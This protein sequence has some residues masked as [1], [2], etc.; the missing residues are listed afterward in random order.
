MAEG[1]LG[2]CCRGRRETSSRP[3]A[4]RTSS[5][6]VAARAPR[7]FQQSKNFL[8][9]VSM[10]PLVLRWRMLHSLEIVQ[11]PHVDGHCPP[12]SPRIPQ[13][14]REGDGFHRDSPAK[15]R[16]G[17]AAIDD[18]TGAPLP[19]P[20]CVY[21]RAEGAR[22]ACV[23]QCACPSGCKKDQSARSPTLLASG[24]VVY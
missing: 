9:R 5:T 3:R 7:L 8:E 15:G 17:R 23:S 14:R 24:T 12:T 6:E 20:R 16:D 18:G 19:K 13:I 1:V 4:R 22:W 10:L 11:A 2:A 21:K